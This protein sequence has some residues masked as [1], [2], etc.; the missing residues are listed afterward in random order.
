MRRFI[1]LF[2]SLIFI[3]VSWSAFALFSNKSDH[4]FFIERS[5]NKKIVQYDVRLTRNDDILDSDPFSVYWVLENGAR[6]E[7]TQLQ[8]TFAYGIDSCKK[9]E[10]N[11]FRISFVALKE[12]EVTI[13]RSE[14]SFRAITAIN[15]KPS[16]LERVYVQSRERWTGL[17]QVIYVD[18]FGRNKETGSPVTERM[19]PK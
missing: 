7:L 13:E 2:G 8:R 1:I 11:K 16:V 9:I 17:P 5:K 18:L 6:R 15:G 12:R 19:S 10:K 3:F 4:L 14:G